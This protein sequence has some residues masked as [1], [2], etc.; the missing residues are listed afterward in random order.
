MVLSENAALGLR[1]ACAALGLL[2]AFV[3]KFGA[4]GMF[5]NDEPKKALAFV[6][7]FG[8]AFFSLMEGQDF[9]F[10]RTGQRV[11]VL[12]PAPAGMAVDKRVVYRSGEVALSNGVSLGLVELPRGE[13]PVVFL[14][15]DSGAELFVDVGGSAYQ[16]VL[17]ATVPAYGLGSFED[18]IFADRVERRDPPGKG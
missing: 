16:T 10:G 6:V 1:V 4:I 18:S 8:A 13:H 2:A 11:W 5:R 17:R 9:L 15:N 7:L 14:L 3:G 12:R